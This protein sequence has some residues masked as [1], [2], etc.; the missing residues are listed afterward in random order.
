[1]MTSQY[2]KEKMRE[3]QIPGGKGD[4][5]T[6]G[7]F[8]RDQILKGM[9]VEMEHTDDPAIAMEI[10]MD[11]LSEDPTYYDKLATI[12]QEGATDPYELKAWALFSEYIYF[13]YFDKMTDIRS[14]DKAKQLALKK[15]PSKNHHYVDYFYNYKK[16]KLGIK[17]ITES[18]SNWSKALDLWKPNNLK[19]FSQAYKALSKEE[20]KALDA[21]MIE[22]ADYGDKE[23][24]MYFKLIPKFKQKYG[25]KEEIMNLN[26]TN[27]T[28]EEAEKM[29][30]IVNEIQNQTKKRHTP[31]YNGSLKEWANM[32]KLIEASA[33][34]L[35]KIYAG[36][37]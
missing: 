14:L 9:Q 12:H 5:K 29:L 3:D 23:T 32:I 37:K 19:P 7:D 20:R 10:T 25:I 11:H 27:I 8:N 24:A 1:M 6:P 15:I 22:L 35:R 4:D 30:R 2:I 21:H 28:P 33:K 13:K 31:L 34:A 18:K 16:K 26:E 17:E 36:I